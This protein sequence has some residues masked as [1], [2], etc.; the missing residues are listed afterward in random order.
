MADVPIREV[1]ARAKPSKF[2]ESGILWGAIG[3]L[4]AAVLSPVTQKLFFVVAWILL[5]I[6]LAKADFFQPWRKFRWIATFGLFVVAG[7]LLLTLWKYTPKMREPPTLDQYA[8]TLAQ[9]FPWFATGPKQTQLATVADTQAQATLNLPARADVSN[10]VFKD[11]PLFTPQRKRAIAKQIT[12]F[13]AYLIGLGIDVPKEFPPIGVETDET[14]APHISQSSGPSYHDTIWMRS[15]QLDDPR[16]ITQ[17]YSGYVFAT[18]LTKPMI[19]KFQALPFDEPL[20]SDARRKVMDEDYYRHDANWAIFRYFV[21]SYWGKPDKEEM[22]C[23]FHGSMLFATYLWEIRERYHKDF[24]DRLIAYTTKELV[25]NPSISQGER[26]PNWFFRAM[27]NADF[28][29]DNKGQK[30]SDIKTI[31]NRCGWLSS[32]G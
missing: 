11:S 5:C 28:V 6:A 8:N 20:E 30:I 3:M 16:M 24:T 15:D 1:S 18:I 32:G 13:K 7:A 17:S 29:V 26:F 4:A 31:L 21:W 22:V 12:E 9:R 25:D 10:F 14:A 27:T 19:P 2:E 23:P